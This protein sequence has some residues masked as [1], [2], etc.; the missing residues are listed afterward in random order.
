M[1]TKAAKAKKAG[2]MR[3]LRAKT[4]SAKQAK[5]VRGGAKSSVPFKYVTVTKEKV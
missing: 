3:N 2:G 4:L 5:D 1:K